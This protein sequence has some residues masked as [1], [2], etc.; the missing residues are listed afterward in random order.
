MDEAA[1]D[2]RTASASA[3]SGNN[4]EPS[5]KSKN[6]KSG[7]KKRQQKKSG[8]RAPSSCFV[9]QERDVEDA[10]S[11]TGLVDTWF[12]AYQAA[13]QLENQFIDDINMKSTEARTDEG[14]GVRV[15][16]ETCQSSAALGLDGAAML[17]L[18]FRSFG[19]TQFRRVCFFAYEESLSSV[20]SGNSN[21]IGDLH[22]NEEGGTK[23]M[24]Q[25]DASLSAGRV[26][27]GYATVDEDIQQP[28]S[29]VCHIR[30]ILVSPSHQRRGIGKQLLHH[31]VKRFSSRHLGLKFANCHDYT[32]FYASAGF[33]VI[34]T[35]ER[36][37]Y[38]AIRR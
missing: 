11:S 10:L 21:G 37:S 25:E 28:T 34:G 29:G 22:L 23:E 38:M 18:V 31:I 35:D 12:Q 15:A 14:V 33:R 19:A 26:P 6:K 5:A 17:P 2:S 20:S 24:E 36:Y 13:F 3:S 32:A 4:L 7:K 9:V 16:G 27:V 1:P 8:K 30:M